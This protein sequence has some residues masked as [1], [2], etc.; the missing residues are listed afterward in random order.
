[1]DTK[2]G[3]WWFLHQHGDANFLGRQAVLQPVTWINDWPIVGNVMHDGVGSMVW[4]H[5]KPVQGY[6]ITKP[7]SSDDFSSEA[8]QPQW[9]WNHAPRNDKWS[10]TER[11][12][13]LRLYASKPA[14][15]GYWG[16]CNTL[17]Q[18]TMGYKPAE[19][20]ALID[21]SKMADGQVAGLSIGSGGGNV[22]MLQVYQENGKRILRTKEGT[23]K[24]EF[25]V[26]SDKKIGSKIWMKVLTDKNKYQFQFSLDGKTFENISKEFYPYF[27]NWRAIQLG[28]ISFNE[29]QN[30]GYV[31]VDWFK[32]EYE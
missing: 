30:D 26:V 24:S 7:Q 13:F 31:D 8:L 14:Y 10:L 12:G 17:T 15:E 22:W 32:Y 16:A 21:V 6:P 9:M 25:D 19:A 3:S 20:T 1:V 28:I 23:K 29:K 11:K 27:N 18:R 2:D 4:E 5:K